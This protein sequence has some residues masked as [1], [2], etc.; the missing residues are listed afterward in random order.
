MTT[1]RFHSVLVSKAQETETCAEN[2]VTSDLGQISQQQASEKY[3]DSLCSYGESSHVHRER[4]GTFDMVPTSNPTSRDS[5]SDEVLP[6][7]FPDTELSD[8]DQDL[9]LQSNGHQQT[10][11]ETKIGQEICFSLFPGRGMVE[12]PSPTRLEPCQ[13]KAVAQ[14]LSPNNGV[15]VQPR[16]S[17]K[18]CN[19]VKTSGDQMDASFMQANR[20]RGK[21]VG[22]PLQPRRH[23]I[24]GSVKQPSYPCES[25]PMQLKGK[26]P[27]SQFQCRGPKHSIPV[28]HQGKKPGVPMQP[29]GH[30][31]SQ[32]HGVPVMRNR[33]Q[34]WRPPTRP[35]RS[36]L[37]DAPVPPNKCHQQ[38]FSMHPSRDLKQH[39]PVQPR[40]VQKQGLSVPPNKNNE[41]QRQA[42]PVLS[43]SQ[44]QGISVQSSRGQRQNRPMQHCRGQKQ[45][46]SI[47]T[48]R[49]QKHCLELRPSTCCRKQ[50]IPVQPS[51]DQE[52][53]KH[54]RRHQ[55][56]QVPTSTSPGKQWSSG[57]DK[58][59]SH[60]SAAPYLSRCDEGRFP[61]SPKRRPLQKQQP[62]HTRNYKQKAHPQ[63]DILGGRNDAMKS[64]PY[65][66]V[67]HWVSLNR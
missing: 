10:S 63:L 65:V 59:Q 57:S 46:M 2:K 66:H 26:S 29:K 50:F 36:Q 34:Y 7:L 28:Q 32:N 56:K 14:D 3:Q 15:P 22:I 49:D 33:D 6:L 38:G 4:Y 9:A 54:P 27:D 39:L 1:Y 20:A 41:G 23:Q 42:I 53:Q 13:G 60:C 61:L 18:Q 40:K 8:S 67:L 51:T 25:H 5:V 55:K 21:S 37:Q 48:S 47:Q 35:S 62:V 44:K 58:A 16:K 19:P 31:R 17:P 24:Q 45:G 12:L 30:R 52:T 43:Q 11:W 64:V